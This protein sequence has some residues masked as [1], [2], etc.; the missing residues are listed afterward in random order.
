MPIGRVEASVP[1]A[2]EPSRGAGERLYLAY[3][4]CIPLGA[5]AM[6]TVTYDGPKDIVLA[7]LWLIGA[8]A[9]A[10]YASF[11]ATYLVA[12]RA[13][14]RVVLAILDGPLWLVLAALALHGWD[15]LDLATWFF[16][17]ESIGVY[18]A[19]AI[20]AV[21]KLGVSGA[22]ASVGIMLACIAGVCFAAGWRLFPELAADSRGALLFAGAVVQ[23]TI[24]SAAIVDANRPVRDSDRAGTAVLAALGVFHLGIGIGAFVRFVVL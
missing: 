20:V 15:L 1:A 8:V 7:V 12:P 6:A 21:R 9:V 2:P 14:W 24:A 22:S 18:L 16:V 3:L 11:V 4:L 17:E 19:I 10:I 13:W 5:T 23:S